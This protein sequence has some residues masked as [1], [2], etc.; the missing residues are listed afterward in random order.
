MPST[1]PAAPHEWLRLRPL[2]GRPSYPVRT[3]IHR[4]RRASGA[5]TMRRPIRSTV[6]PITGRHCAPCQKELGRYH[7]V[8]LRLTSIRLP[9]EYDDESLTPDDT[10]H[11]GVAHA[12]AAATAV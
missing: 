1:L 6:E 9:A 12:D 2:R 7:P 11:A 10:D 4:S 8:T 3:C 5:G